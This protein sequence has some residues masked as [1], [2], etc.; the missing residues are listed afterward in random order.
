[1]GS[2]SI[3][4][5]QCSPITDYPQVRMVDVGFGGVPFVLPSKTAIKYLSGAVKVK[6]ESAITT[7]ARYNA[8]KTM[9]RELSG[10]KQAREDMMESYEKF[11]KERWRAR[12][13][14]KQ[15]TCSGVS[16]SYLGEVRTNKTSSCLGWTEPRVEYYI[17]MTDIRKRLPGYIGG[18]R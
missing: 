10:H 2:V 9:E 15:R 16:S 1:M 8:R 5:G 18:V 7:G 17:G 6:R 13:E 14:P 4:G 12:T 11:E 3:A